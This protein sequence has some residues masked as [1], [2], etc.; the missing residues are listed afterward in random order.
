MKR[1]LKAKTLRLCGYSTRH[2]RRIVKKLVDN[3]VKAL[4]STARVPR[5]SVIIDRITTRSPDNKAK[6]QNNISDSDCASEKSYPDEQFLHSDI[7]SECSLPENDSSWVEDDDPDLTPKEQDLFNCKLLKMDSDSS[8]EMTSDDESSNSDSPCKYYKSN[9]SMDEHGEENLLRK[10]LRN[11]ALIFHINLVA[12]TALLSILKKITYIDLPLDART[13]LGTIRRTN[14]SNIEGGEYYHFGLQ[15]AIKAILRENDRKGKPLEHVKLMVHIDGLPISKSASEG[16]WLI[17]CSEI[18]SDNVYPVGAFYGRKKPRDANEFLR[19]FV[20]EA[21]ELC[22]N[23]LNDNTVKVSCEALI[24]DAPAKSF[25]F[26]LKGHTGYDSCSKCL[27]R[28]EYATPKIS[29]KNGKRKG[30]ICFPGIGP[31]KLKNDDDFARNLYQD[32]DCDKIPILSSI[33]RFGCISSVPIDYMHLILLGVM[34]KLIT[35]WLTGPLKVRLSASD[36]NK[37]SQKLLTLRF[38]APREFGRKPRSLL[39]YAFWKATEFRSFLLYTGPVALKNILPDEMY[40]HFLLLHTAVSILISEVHLHDTRNIDSAHEMLQHFVKDFIRIYGKEY[41]SHNVHNLLHV[42]LDVK[43]YGV[44][45][46]YS[47]FRFENYM[48]TIKKMIRKGN[49]PL[50]QMARRYAEIEAAEE[51]SCSTTE[52]FLQKPHNSGPVTENCST[53]MQQYK[54]FKNKSYTIDCN[55]VKDSCILL[56]NGTFASIDNIVEY[57]YNK[58]CIIG[59]KLVPSEKLYDEPDSRLI[60]IHIMLSSD[61]TR[62][63]WSI[64]KI[65][66]KAWKI[67]CQKGKIVIPLLHYE[68][69]G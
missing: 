36:V 45:D 24:C 41:V 9:L 63:S 27:I 49:K 10:K 26:Y 22:E 30:R 21:I 28:G 40:C 3:D 16:L 39:D 20:D 13:L 50:E 43:K 34:K 66:G 68:G 60:N 52:S 33:P 25:A 56:K 1:V 46:R 11:W 62:Y 59:R 7:S 17:L 51:D 65:L 38:S 47:A 53:I 37:I 44:L 5:D 4:H 14:I 29:M 19:P 55:N 42:Y 18:T 6:S 61:A 31:F 15:R 32:F 69:H 48:S 23:G 64:D 2:L 54:V 12:L 67:P 8:S 35:L 57:E 58:I